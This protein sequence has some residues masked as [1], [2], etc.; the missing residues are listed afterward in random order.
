MIYTRTVS[1]WRRATAAINAQREVVARK[2]AEI[3]ELQ[4]CIVA[5]QHALYDLAV[6]FRIALEQ[7]E[8]DIREDLDQMISEMADNLCQAKE[9]V[10]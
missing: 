8:V 4:R 7:P 6:G 1:L 5:H 10:L 3:G 2:D 9:F